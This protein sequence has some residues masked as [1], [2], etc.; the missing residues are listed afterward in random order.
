VAT[1]SLSIPTTTLLGDEEECTLRDHLLAVHS[2]TSTR[3]R[4]TP[5]P[6]C[7]GVTAA[8]CN[9]GRSGRNLP[10]CEASSP[11]SRLFCLPMWSTTAAVPKRAILTCYDGQAGAVTSYLG[12]PSVVGYPLYDADFA[13]DGVCA[14]SF[15]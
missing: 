8:P 4:I 10:K 7:R 1:S 9:T 6:R 3:P 14:F 15:P 5:S 13:A 11:Y 2:S 12:V